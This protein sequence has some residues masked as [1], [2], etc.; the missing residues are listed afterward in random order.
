LYFAVRSF[1]SIQLSCCRLLCIAA[2]LFFLNSVLNLCNLPLQVM[3]ISEALEYIPELM[4][5]MG[6]LLCRLP[7]CQFSE[8]SS[9]RSPGLFD[10]CVL[11][12]LNLY[13]LLIC[14]FNLLIFYTLF[15]FLWTFFC[16]YWILFSWPA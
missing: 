11:I 9:H 13:S 6:Y 14:L 4:F 15:K 5:L 7:V 1:Y 2:V 12:F 10:L 16:W 8:Q 3:L